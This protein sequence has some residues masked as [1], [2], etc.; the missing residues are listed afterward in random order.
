MLPEIAPPNSN[1]IPDGTLFRWDLFYRFER[2]SLSILSPI[3]EDRPP[4]HFDPRDWGEFP[5]ML[6]NRAPQ[7]AACELP[8]TPVEI[9]HR[10]A[11]SSP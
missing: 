11:S 9:T 3:L 6:P 4:N 1:R 2:Y 5:H 7:I 10:V 8:P